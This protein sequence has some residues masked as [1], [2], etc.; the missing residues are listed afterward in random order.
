M[1]LQEL[2]NIRANRDKPKEKKKYSI[3]KVSEKK[4][5]QLD[6][7]KSLRAGDEDTLMEKWFKARRKSMVNVCQC[8]CGSKSCK[9]D[10]M[11][12]RHSL[13]HVFPKSKF[14]SIMYNPLNW[15]E[16]AFWGG[17]HSIMDDTS[18][19]RWPNMGDW[20]NIK[21]I[22]HALA[23]LLTDEERATKFYSKLEK[24]VYEN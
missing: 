13:A 19:E 11:Y 21:E 5:K 9:D 20:D 24:L 14:P 3:R 17:C 7:E 1:G 15:V 2:Q 8:G 4:Q 18:M 10:D 22:F 6:T 12:F 23:P 16:R